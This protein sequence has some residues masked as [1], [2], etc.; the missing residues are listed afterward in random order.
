MNLP[1]RANSSQMGEEVEQQRNYAFEL[2]NKLL[3][4]DVKEYN[5]FVVHNEVPIINAIQVF[6]EVQD[7]FREKYLGIDKKQNPCVCTQLVNHNLALRSSILGWRAK[8]L[9]EILQSPKIENNS[10]QPPQDNQRG[11]IKKI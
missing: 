4:S 1:P 3:I 6:G 9:V 5:T 8:Q 10:F 2:G 11:I 7:Y